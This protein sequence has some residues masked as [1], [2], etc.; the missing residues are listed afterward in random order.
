MSE[1]DTP[2]QPWRVMYAGLDSWMPAEGEVIDAFGLRRAGADS[3]A[4]SSSPVLGRTADEEITHLAIISMSSRKNLVLLCSTGQ[5]HRRTP[6]RMLH[7]GGWR[8]I[9]S[10]GFCRMLPLPATSSASQLPNTRLGKQSR[11]A[12]CCAGCH[13]WP[14]KSSGFEHGLKS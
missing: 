14:A 3:L 11:L 2:L 13:S 7:V 9:K 8:Q 5:M 1:I 6:G 12:A 10:F 4:D